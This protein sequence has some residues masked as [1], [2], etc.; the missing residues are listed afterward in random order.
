M[1]L[2]ARINVGKATGREEGSENFQNSLSGKPLDGKTKLNEGRK[3][4]A[5]HKREK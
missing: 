4:E 1:S 5:S 3:G 2:D